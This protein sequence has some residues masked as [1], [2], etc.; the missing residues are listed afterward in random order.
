MRAL[1]VL[2][3]LLGGC[4]QTIDLDPETPAGVSDPIGDACASGTTQIARMEVR[5][6]EREP[7]CDWGESGN[8]EPAQSVVTARTEDI[9]SVAMPEG[10]ALCD[11]NF[12]FGSTGDDDDDDDDDEQSIR[13]DDF[14][15]LT[16]DDAVLTSSYAPLV[17]ALAEEGHLRIYDW[18]RLAGLPIGF[19][20]EDAYCLGEAQ[21]LSSCE[22]PPPETSGTIAL[23]FGDE[24][25][26]EL[27]A[28]A[29][30]TGRYEFSFITLGDNDAAV[31][32]SHAAFH[33]TVR[34]EYVSP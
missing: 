2:G 4:A 20:D 34:V 23:D 32:C 26:T 21:G 19:D 5:F 15:L 6:P 30:D 27:A 24:I 7:G 16:L 10:A 12:D 29:Y 25:V 18:D 17:D 8:L 1:P 14:F 13:Y 33:F 9:V 22:I 31:D 11:V 3:L 28:Y